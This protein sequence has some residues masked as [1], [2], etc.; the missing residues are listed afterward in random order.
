M[1]GP[2]LA[3][4]GSVSTILVVGPVATSFVRS[5]I[6]FQNIMIVRQRY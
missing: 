4:G 6:P 3:A 1:L 5:G 2:I